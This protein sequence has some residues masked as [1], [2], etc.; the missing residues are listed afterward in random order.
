MREW[1]LIRGTFIGLWISYKI[2]INQI[3]TPPKHIG[4]SLKISW[5]GIFIH[6]TALGDNRYIKMKSNFS[7]WLRK[8]ILVCQ[9]RQNMWSISNYCTYQWHTLMIMKYHH[10]GTLWLKILGMK[11]SLTNVPEVT[12]LRHNAVGMF[13]GA[14]A[15]YEVYEACYSQG[16]PIKIV[17]W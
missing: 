16:S 15:D 11:W 5:T 2:F 10:S 13:M 17:L 14:G 6:I 1:V 3:I 12:S 4:M 9:H 7:Y 8:A